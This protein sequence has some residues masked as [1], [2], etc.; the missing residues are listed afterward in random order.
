MIQRETLADGLLAHGRYHLHRLYAMHQPPDTSNTW[1]KETM[2][3][4]T[5]V[6]KY[7]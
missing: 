1:K 3:K 6:A 2:P 7:D 5:F 4:H